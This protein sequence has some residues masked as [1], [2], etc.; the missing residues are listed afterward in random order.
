VTGLDCAREREVVRMVLTRRWAD[1]AD[2]LRTHADGCAIC[3]DVVSITTLLRDDRDAA[4]HELKVPAAGQ[5]W[6][7]AA[8][9]ARLEGTHAAARPLTWAH[10]VT[11][12]CAA[13]L[14][15]GAARLAWPSLEPVI[16]SF[17]ARVMSVSPTTLEVV[18]IGVAA[19]QRS[20]PFAFAAAAC[21]VLA[22]LALYLAL[23]DD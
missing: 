2:E 21:L 9:R 15:I 17:A 7:R 6:W 16:S 22:P 13:G 20:L 18:E 10:A 12:A 1:A 4:M 19:L 11:G 3:R 14:T 5:V 23:T 8:V